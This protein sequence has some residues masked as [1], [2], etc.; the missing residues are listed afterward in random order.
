MQVNSRE[1]RL[2]NET[3]S[4]L[5]INNF[6]VPTSNVVFLLCVTNISDIA[7]IINYVTKTKKKIEIIMISYNR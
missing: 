3:C 2:F 6:I 4:L 1:N 7:S 5:L